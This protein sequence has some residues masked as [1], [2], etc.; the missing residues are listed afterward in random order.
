MSRADAAPD[1][2]EAAG[3][4]SGHRS[5]STELDDE[6][7]G[8]GSGHRSAST[9]LDASSQSVP[10]AR[11]WARDVS[12]RWDLGDLDSSLLHLV[13]ELVTNCVLHARTASVLRLEQ[14][15]R[16]GL[17]RCSVSDFSRVRPR[18]R[19]H[20]A[21]ATTGR[22]LQMLDR[23]ST[24]WGVEPSASGKTVW[25][26]LREGATGH[27]DLEDWEALAD[28]EPAV[29]PADP[30]SASRAVLSAVRG[31]GTAGT[32]GRGWSKGLAA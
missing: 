8:E 15:Q 18:R 23:L 2:D 4:G 7:A 3:E 25:F 6:A 31:S 26:E 21:D 12:E 20:S 27:L 24:S 9:E 19:S 17:V 11:G 29:T 13:T 22:G 32:T 10:A 5:A 16:S 1:D 30:H 28:A 14:D